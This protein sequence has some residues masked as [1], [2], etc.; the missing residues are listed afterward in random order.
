[1]PTRRISRWIA[2]LLLSAVI[3]RTGDAASDL[4]VPLQKAHDLLGHTVEDQDGQDVGRLKDVVFEA[5]TG[6]VTVAVLSSGGFAGLGEKL[7]MVPWYVL[8]QPI[9]P[10]TVRL[11]MPAEQLKGAPSFEE[12]QWPDLE[13]RH[14]TDAVQVYYGNYGKRPALGKQLPPKTAADER[15]GYVPQRYLRANVVLQGTI[16]NLQGQRLGEMKEMVIDTAAGQ[17][18]YVVLGFGGVLGLGEKWFAIPWSELR[19]SPG[20]G[21]FT[22]DMDQETLQKAPGFDKDHWP[23]TAESLKR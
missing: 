11:S 1:M 13:D 4:P 15:G 2:L 3:V 9:S 16:A 5:V 17:V 23:Q 22:L 8:Q 10:E 18:T 21:T 12:E 7:F 19:E 14:W 20:L 6:H